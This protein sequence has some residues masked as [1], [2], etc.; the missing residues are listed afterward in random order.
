MGSGVGEVMSQGSGVG[1]VTQRSDVSWA[2][3]LER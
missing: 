2:V 3:V 1:E